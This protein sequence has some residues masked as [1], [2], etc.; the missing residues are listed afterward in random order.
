MGKQ[1]HVHSH[2]KSETFLVTIEPSWFTSPIWDDFPAEREMSHSK[3]HGTIIEIDEFNKETALAFD[4]GS[5]FT[6]RLESLIGEAYAYL[7]DKGFK[8]LLVSGTGKPKQVKG[9]PIELCFENKSEKREAIRPFMYKAKYGEVDVFFAVGY[10]SRLETEEE[11]DNKSGGSYTAGAAGWT[12]VCNDRVVL[13]NDRTVKTGWE[14]GGVPRFHT[15]FSSIAGI[16]EFHSKDTRQLPVTTTK[17]GIDTGKDIY[18]RT[19]SKM[20]EATKWFT[21]NTNTWK[22]HE[23][24]L[25]SRFDDLNKLGLSELKK[26]AES[27][28]TSIPNKQ[29]AKQY[30]PDLPIK[31][32]IATT[33]RIVFVKPIKEI[34]SVSRFLFDEVFDASMVGEA[35]FDRTLK[36][37]QE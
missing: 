3:T 17:R 15:Q 4:E 24:E 19:L 29:G 28:Y 26:K 21:K 12:V 14:T 34:E 2:H 11:I 30:R 13:S 23:N 1:C 5:S 22:R 16:V 9:F 6:E 25:K 32:Q 36:D 33:R 10:R 31:K 18:L 20:Q 8:I 27:L 37:S 7:I 35:C